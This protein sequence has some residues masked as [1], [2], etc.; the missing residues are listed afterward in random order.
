MANTVLKVENLWKQY[1]L[2]SIGGATLRDDLSIWWNKL[3]GKEASQL[4]AI[5]TND[6]A[7]SSGDYVWALQ[8]INFEIKQGE[9]LGVIGKNGAGKSTL[10]KILSKV[11]GPTRGSIKTKGRIASLLEV[12]TGFHPELTGRENV[13]L[14]GA[15]LGMNKAEIRAKFDEIVDFSGVGSYID[16]P[17]KR[18]SSGMY[19]RLAFGVAAHLEPEI[20][21]V[22]EVLAVG[23]AEFQEKAIGKMRD[24]SSGQGRTVLFVSHNMSMVKSLCEEAILL[25]HGC[26]KMKGGANKV[27]EKYLSMGIEQQGKRVWDNAADAPKIKDLLLVHSLS[28]QKQNQEIDTVFDVKEEI[29]IAVQYEVFKQSFSF[30]VH[31]YIKNQNGVTVFVAMDN[32]HNPYTKEPT[33][34]GR[35]TEICKIPKDF[36]NE[37]V[38]YVEIL[39]CT[40]PTGPNYVTYPDALSFSVTDDMSPTGVRGDWFREWPSSIIRTSFEWQIIRH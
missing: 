9:V 16:T 17:V 22:D 19:V 12:G 23:D 33:P 29:N 6:R 30:Q 18:Y 35:Y 7:N 37:G 20:L 38:Y 5:N 10:L 4:S 21:I 11:T 32:L 25:E 13:F 31:F 36:L 27:V 8:D 15:I 24:V 26:L 1:R 2:G 28:L 34:V 39:I 3:L 14:N 40:N